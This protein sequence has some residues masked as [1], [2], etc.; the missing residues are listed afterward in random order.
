MQEDDPSRLQQLDKSCSAEATAWGLNDRQRT[1]LF[2]SKRSK[3]FL[4]QGRPGTVHMKMATAL[5]HAHCGVSAVVHMAAANKAVDDLVLRVLEKATVLEEHPSRYRPKWGS[6]SMVGRGGEDIDP[7]VVPHDWRALI[8]AAGAGSNYLKK[9]VRQKQRS[10]LQQNCM[11]HGGTCSTFAE[12]P[13]GEGVGL[14]NPAH[15]CAVVV[16]DEAGQVTEAA[17]YVVFLADARCTVL[18]G[19]PAQFPPLAKS[20]EALQCGHHISA[21]VN[22]GG[23]SQCWWPGAVRRRSRWSFSGTPSFFRFGQWQEC[24]SSRRRL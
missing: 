8:R 9:G 5:V 13:V 14:L 3:L 23:A 18:L 16:V 4:G 2:R 10:F 21:Q 17:A 7:A 20:E 1:A 11:L 15:G 24:W 22:T 12:V 19:D 6:V